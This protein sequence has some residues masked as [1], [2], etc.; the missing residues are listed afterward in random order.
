MPPSSSSST[1]ELQALRTELAAMKGE[2]RVVTVERDLL[3]ERLKAYQRQLFA[4]RSEVRGAEQRDL[5][6]NEAEALA[7]GCEPAQE[8]EAEQSVE[9]GA[10]ERKKR[11]RKPLNP[12]LLREVVRHELPESE[13]VCAHD[14]HALV[15][16]G[17]EISEQLDIV[18]Q[19][20]RVIQHQRI[21]Y[22]CPCCDLGIKVTPAP[23]RIIP[24]GL[25]TESAL[26]WVVVS[27]FADALPLYRIAALLHRFGGDLSR[28]TLAASVVRVGMAVQP[29]INRKR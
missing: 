13:R 16:I 11:G 22:A 28:G 4:S 27:K 24:K 25:L 18:P 19:Q 29:L 21:K 17:A 14:G 15:E 20:V 7:T 1:D 10:H 9:V 6:L 12:M 5:F 3:R 8:T 26:A 2:L 23:S